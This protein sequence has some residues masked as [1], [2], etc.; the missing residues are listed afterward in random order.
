[1]LLK[2]KRG[3][4]SRK[5]CL[6]QSA[7]RRYTPQTSLI[8]VR[9]RKLKKGYNNYKSIP[10]NTFC[11][12][13]HLDW[14]LFLGS[15]SPL[16]TLGEGMGRIMMCHGCL[17]GP[18]EQKHIRKHHINT[19]TPSSLSSPIQPRPIALGHSSEKRPLKPRSLS[20]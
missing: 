11:H 16:V 1:M 12:F 13:K 18:P 6:S 17:P 7:R 4:R 20:P 8:H 3:A 2:R 10:Q 15:L 19:N 5:K 9:I 14:D